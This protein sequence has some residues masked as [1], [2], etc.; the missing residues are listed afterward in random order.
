MMSTFLKGYLIKEFREKKQ[1]TQKELA[2]KLC[3]SEKTVSKWET[4]NGLPDIG[5]LEDLSKSLGVSIAELLT[6]EVRANS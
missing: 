3:V 2:E 1:L 4:N 5:I 6:G